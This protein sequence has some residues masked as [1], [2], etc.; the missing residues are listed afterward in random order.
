MPFRGQSAR[1]VR[2]VRGGRTLGPRLGAAPPTLSP[3]RSGQVA[4]WARGSQRSPSATVS[5]TGLSPQLPP[6]VAGRWA[7]EAAK[8]APA[9]EKAWGSGAQ[10]ARAAPRPEPGAAAFLVRRR[11]S[12]FASWKR[13]ETQM[14]A[15]LTFLKRK[16]FEEIKIPSNYLITHRAALPTGPP[17]PAG[18]VGN[19]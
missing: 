2:P 19:W 10:W 17:F 12:C 7:R 3:P 1:G 18:F 8:A 14:K 15:H 16:Y 9:P 5:R 4:Q 13:K 11:Q 6:P